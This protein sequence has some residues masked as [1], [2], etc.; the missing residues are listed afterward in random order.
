MR[1]SKGGI[2]KGEIMKIFFFLLTIIFSRSE[3]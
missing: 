1:K 2:I 3:E